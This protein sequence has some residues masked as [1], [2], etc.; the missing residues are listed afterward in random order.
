MIRRSF[1]GL[2]KPKLK[3]PVVESREQGSVKEIALPSKAI[4]FI[5]DPDIRIEDLILRAG[6]KVKTGQKLQL[7]ENSEKYLVS[8]V[9]GTVDG[10]S[11]YTGTLGQSHVSISVDVADEDQW[12]DEFKNLDAPPSRK[13]PENF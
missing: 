5:K 8:T 7:T 10:I 2:A 6:E 11:E 4:L 3:Y 9:T 13:T 12:D 1:F